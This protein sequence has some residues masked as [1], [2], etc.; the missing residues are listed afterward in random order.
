M[1]TRRAALSD[2]TGLTHRHNAEAAAHKK[3]VTSALA[4]WKHYNTTGRTTSADA[5]LFTG[6]A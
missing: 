6:G 5:A 1:N 2:P 4:H 3:P